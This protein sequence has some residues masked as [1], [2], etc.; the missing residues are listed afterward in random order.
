MTVLVFRDGVFAADTGETCGPLVTNT[1]ARKVVRLPDGALVAGAGL[2]CE[3]EAFREWCRTGYRLPRPKISEENI[4]HAGGGLEAILVK[5]DGTILKFIDNDPPFTVVEGW[6]SAGIGSTAMNTLLMLG[7]TARDVVA[8]MIKHGH[9]A[10]G[11]VFSMK[12]IPDGDEDLPG[13]MVLEPPEPDQVSD[14]EV[15]QHVFGMAAELE[16]EPERKAD[17][18][19]DSMGLR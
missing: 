12:L 15:I 10:Y 19:R 14:A 17:S 18:W 13:I 2:C 9:G 3:I 7:W 16:P 1:I 5:P 11:D 6:A 8:W 4:N